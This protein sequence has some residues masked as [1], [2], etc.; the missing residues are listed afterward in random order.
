MAHTRVRNVKHISQ[1]WLV[2][3]RHK[4]CNPRRTSSDI[5]PIGFLIPFVIRFAEYRTWTLCIN[6][7]LLR[8]C[9][10]IIAG[11][12]FQKRS[13]FL[14]TGCDFRYSL[15]GNPGIHSYLCIHHHRSIPLSELLLN[16]FAGASATAFSFNRPL[17]EGRS[18]TATDFPLLMILSVI[19]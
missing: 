11:H 6:H 14:C 9:E 2:P 18:S 10:L 19:P 13:P 5:S 4:Q 15:P 16:I 8:I 3:I 7:D 1:I 17:T 12:C